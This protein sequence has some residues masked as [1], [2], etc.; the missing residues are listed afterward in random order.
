MN[1]M[2]SHEL[3]QKLLKMP[4]LPVYTS[5]DQ[6]VESVTEDTYDT[7]TETDLRCVLLEVIDE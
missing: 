6:V 1:V 5:E 4:D 2:T 7:A 3:A